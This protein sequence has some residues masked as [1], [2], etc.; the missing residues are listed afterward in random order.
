M[1]YSP[2]TPPEGMPLDV[3]EECMAIGEEELG[4]TFMDECS[5][6]CGS[7]LSDFESPKQKDMTLNKGLLD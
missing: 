3:W 4:L 1:N 7:V 6:E 2:P 5:E